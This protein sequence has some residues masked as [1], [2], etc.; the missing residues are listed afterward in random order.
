MDQ[1]SHK[2]TKDEVQAEALNKL[3]NLRNAGVEI[4]MGV[5]KT[6]LGLL[7]M[8]RMKNMRN[9]ADIKF[10][11]VAPKVAI[12]QSWL[13]EAEK[14]N[15]LDLIPNI[16]FSTYRSLK[17]NSYFQDVIYLDECHSLKESH[18]EYLMHAK[19]AGARMIGLT[20]TYPKFKSSEK[21]IMCNRYCPKVYTYK[22][23]TAVEDKILNDYRI[24][25]HM[26]DMSN[27][28]DLD[29]TMGSKT[30]KTSEFKTYQYWTGR[31]ES[32]KTPKDLQIL[33]VMRMKAMMGFKSKE[34]K[35]LELLA[36]RKTKTLLFANTQEQ[37]DRLAPHSFHS[38]NP[39]SEENLRLFKAGDID[40]LS[41]VEQLSE[42]V[43]IPNLKSGIIMHAY[44]N[45]RK[46][47]QKLGRLL[48][49]NPDDT[50]GVHILCYRK[51]VDEE[52]VKSA[53]SHLNQEKI[54]WLS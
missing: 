48:R 42:G 35:V 39:R 9:K 26:V 4:S 28:D 30:W 54:I 47:A 49:L 37:A 22:T 15:M 13:D 14:N 18:D 1:S 34:R 27:E 33:R 11:V 2:K 16:K 29:I 19:M 21:A 23:D 10:L 25:V 12:F 24:Y 43:T 17:K 45:N 41:A 20:G 6:L 5:G 52:W 50:S 53:L 31:I 40:L 3:M 8:Q 36:R 44:S 51:T 38:N 32:A 46:T 7:H